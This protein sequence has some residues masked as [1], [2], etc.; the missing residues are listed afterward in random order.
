[1]SDAIYKNGLSLTK[2]TA[3]AREDTLYDELINSFPQHTELLSAQEIPLSKWTLLARLVVKQP[4]DEPATYFLK[5]AAGE[6]GRVMIEGEFHSMSELYKT[7]PELVPKPYAWGTLKTFPVETYYLLVEFL[8]MSDGLPEPNQLCAKLARLHN[9]SVS[10]TGKFGFDIPTCQGRIPQAVAWES[11]WNLYF[12]SLLR[13][14]IALDDAEN[15][16]W[17]TLSVLEDRLLAH[18]VPRLL[19]NLTKDGRVVKPSLIHGDLWEGNTGISRETGNIYLF[20]AAAMYAHHELE[21]GNWRC[22]YNKI[23]HKVY[24]QTYFRYNGPSEPTE[25]W[26]DRNRLYCIYYNILYSVNHR[27]QGQAVRQTA[28]DDMYYLI[29]KFAPFPEGQ[30]PARI[31]DADR[32]VLSDEGDHTKS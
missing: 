18:V 27:S 7:M 9:T 23:H 25:E 17:D 20:D 22:S 29:D 19:G 13:H 12:A 32:A 28:F 16:S 31:K 5:C 14:V 15:G 30:G 4:D 11:N 24:T 6:A 1:M 2:P 26:A 21:I 3:A 8:D 10:P